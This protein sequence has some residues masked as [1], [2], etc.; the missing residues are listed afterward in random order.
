[1]AECTLKESAAINQILG[2]KVNKYPRKQNIS[3]ATKIKMK[4][5]NLFPQWH[6]LT[7]E[8]QAKYYEQVRNY[9]NTGIIIIDNNGGKI[10]LYFNRKFIKQIKRIE[11]D[12]NIKREK[13]LIF[14]S[15]PGKEGAATAHAGKKICFEKLWKLFFLNYFLKKKKTSKLKCRF[16]ICA[17]DFLLFADVPGLV[18]QGQLCADQGNC[19]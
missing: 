9:C 13:I 14:F 15:F 19:K 11:K 2:R 4:N 12:Q 3:V 17:D 1:M 6:A 5:W 18:C 8:E 16:Q 10:S 7:R